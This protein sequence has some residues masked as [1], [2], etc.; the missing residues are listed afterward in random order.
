MI[1]PIH[2]VV[3]A[4]IAEAVTRLY[5]IPADDPVLAAIP[6]EPAPR[7]ALGDLAVP[8]AFELARRLRKPPRAI[9]QE[10]AGALGSIEGITRIEAAPNGY[11][12][13]FL[14]RPAFLRQRLAGSAPPAST[15]GKAIVEHTAI[16]PNKAAHIGHLRNAALGDTF[17]RLLRFLGR[18]VEIQNYIDDTGVQV[19][20]VAVGFRELE[21]KSIDEI[22]TIADA[23]KFDYYC[24]DL[25]ARVTEWYEEDKERLT[26]RAHALHDI[27]RG[28][29]ETA[30]LAQ[31][32]A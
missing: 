12:N 16:N 6:V 4:R 31:F 20:D 22:R 18:E 2:R 29:N 23:G 5:A 15:E 26:V 32:I 27:E 3:R 25:Y 10:L 19:A 9:A 13:F 21:H 14:D 28:G 8:L 30:E 24:W 17:G 1:L 7:R 11:V